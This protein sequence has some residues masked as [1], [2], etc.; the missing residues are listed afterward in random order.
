MTTD[1]DF[2]EYQ[3]RVL[4][5]DIQKYSTQKE[6]KMTIWLTGDGWLFKA[7]PDKN[8][9]QHLDHAKLK[10]MT[11]YDVEGGTIQIVNGKKV[12]R[13][14]SSTKWKNGEKASGKLN[15]GQQLLKTEKYNFLEICDITMGNEK[16]SMTKQV[17][18][19]CF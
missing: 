11:F 4:L 15:L 18:Y 7:L 16:V 13:V 9:G 10:R 12:L 19:I 6:T 17:C 1:H 5:L 14:T 3:Q 2:Q 8:S